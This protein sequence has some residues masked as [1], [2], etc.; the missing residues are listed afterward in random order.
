MDSITMSTERLRLLM[1]EI[2]EKKFHYRI[3]SANDIIGPG[4]GV[5]IT[6]N[7]ELNEKHLDWFE[8]RNPAPEGATYVDVVLYEEA[9]PSRK[10]ADVP[11]DLE[12]PKERGRS[13]RE[14]EERAHQ[15]SRAVGEKAEAVAKQASS[16]YR[17]IGKQDFSAAD[18]RQP[19]TESV[20]REFERQIKGFHDAVQKAM[21]EYLSGNTLVMDLILKYQLDKKTVRHALNVAAFATEMATQLAFK[22]EGEGQEYLENLE[23]YFGKFDNEEL[24]AQLG[25]DVE[26]A[27]ELE[28]EE[29][30]EKRRL[31][32]KRELVEIFL[33]GFM[34]DCGLWNEPF[35]L[36][37]GHEVKGAKLVWELREV[38]QY[39]PS[40]VKIVLFHSDLAR[41]AKRYGV[42]KLIEAPDDP[43]RSTFTREFFRTKKEAKTALELRSGNFKANILEEED[44]RKVLPVALAEQYI[45]QTQDI[46]AKQRWEVIHGMAR[47]IRNG[48]FL[49]YMVVMCNAQV[50]V[51]APR[52]AYVKLE[53]HLSVMVERNNETRRA[54]RI[55]LDGFE[56][57]SIGHGGDRNSPHLITLFF[58]HGD[59]GRE[60]AA[61]V[62][63]QDPAL[64]DRSA[65]IDSRMY[66]PVG[67]FKSNLSV[68][69][70]GFISED[71]YEKI[72]G[73][74]E[75]E[76][77]RRAK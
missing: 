16:V 66:I 59:G 35:F 67:R 61:Y 21:D 76:F 48:L 8:R 45:T 36:H 18:L 23:S 22:D 25:E 3:C 31:L 20:L 77:E 40:L 34:H 69:V 33:G 46:N 44:L 68:R 37:E 7:S 74:Y 54:Q 13:A 53:G 72:L 62:S 4:G 42:V 14:R 60:K 71:V 70:T 47:H 30:E 58:M 11:K 10:P 65:G 24:L 75:K 41:L 43:E 56:A 2:D 26:R 63:P 19:N 27:D 15:H 28:H 73:E 55:E 39:A 51:I 32:F 49:R 12:L 52:R 64:W 57:G 29:V 5:Y 9:P 1:R 6:A 50:E 38:R 17:S